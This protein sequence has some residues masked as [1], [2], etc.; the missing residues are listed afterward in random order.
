MQNSL[1]KK[2]YYNSKYVTAL[3]DAHK[4]DKSNQIS[5]TNF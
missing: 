2:Y 5:K 1:A 4:L 3:N